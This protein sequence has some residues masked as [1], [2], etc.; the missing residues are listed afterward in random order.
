METIKDALIGRVF[1]KLLRVSEK[2]TCNKNYLK[3]NTENAAFISVYALQSEI[4]DVLCID[5]GTVPT[6]NCKK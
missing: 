3:Y 4:T 1:A 2:E 5:Q 6:T